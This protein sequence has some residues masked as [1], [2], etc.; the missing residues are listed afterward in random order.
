M[1]LRRRCLREAVNRSPGSALRAVA[2]FG[3]VQI[4]ERPAASLL[5]SAPEYIGGGSTRA[6]REIFSGVRIQCSC[7]ECG[8]RCP[9]WKTS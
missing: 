3:R 4:P 2:Q 1:H 5:L 9:E 7:C 6:V 8:V